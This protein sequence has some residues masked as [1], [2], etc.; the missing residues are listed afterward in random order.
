M[1]KPGCTICGHDNDPS[2]GRFI[3]EDTYEGELNNPLSLNLYTYVQNNPLIYN[4]PT[5]HMHNDIGNAYSAGD[6]AVLQTYQSMFLIGQQENNLL[7]MQ[8][9]HVQQ[10][11]SD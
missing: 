1:P 6:R 7:M 5:G 10:I 9:A 8:A 2:V 3:S 4:D 11:T